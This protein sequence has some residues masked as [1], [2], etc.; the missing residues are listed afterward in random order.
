MFFYVHRKYHTGRVH[1]AAPGLTSWILG[2]ER[3][4]KGG[5]RKGRRGQGRDG[6]A[7]ERGLGRERGQNH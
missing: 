6:A 5:K 3:V 4:M 1:C 7:K 2:G